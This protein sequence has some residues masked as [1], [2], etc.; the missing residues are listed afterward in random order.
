V[1]KNSFRS[2]VIA[3]KVGMTSVYDQW[4]Q[5]V[6]LTVLH[7]DRCQ[8]IGVK[9]KEDFGYDAVVLGSG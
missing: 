9:K 8:V 6:P 3:Q 2:G 7:V 5:F 1:A 4:A